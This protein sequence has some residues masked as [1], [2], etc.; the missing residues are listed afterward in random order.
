MFYNNDILSRRKSGLGIVWLAATLGD[1]SVI[2]R[3]T[4]KDI[5]GVRISAAC[6]FLRSPTEPL[7]L[8]LSSQLMYGVVKLYS[9][10]W[11]LLYQGR[12]EYA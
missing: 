2:R 11:E 6:D 4:R 12:G 3:L 1:R 9:S 7:A 8:R 10:Q 5:L